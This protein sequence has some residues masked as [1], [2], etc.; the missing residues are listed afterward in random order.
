VL[1]ASPVA[2]TVT[3]DP[4]LPGTIYTAAEEIKKAGG[5]ALAVQCDIRSEEQVSVR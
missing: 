5:K 1:Y 3:E 4:R 2:K